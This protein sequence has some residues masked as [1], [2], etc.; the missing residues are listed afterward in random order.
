MIT[1]YKICPKIRKE[2]IYLSNPTEI[3]T[4]VPQGNIQGHYSS[5]STYVIRHY[6]IFICRLVLLRE[7]SHINDYE[8]NINNGFKNINQW[9]DINNL[10]INMNNISINIW[11]KQ[12]ICFKKIQMKI[13]NRVTW[14]SQSKLYKH[15]KF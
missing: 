3:K 13:I 9:S 1:L 6:F 14:K 4:G 8:C 10:N 15:T 11:P 12:T 7:K 2:H 5:L